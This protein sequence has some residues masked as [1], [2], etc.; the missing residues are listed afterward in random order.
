MFSMAFLLTVAALGLWVFAFGMLATIAEELFFAHKTSSRDSRLLFR[1]DGLPVWKTTNYDR[2]VSQHEYHDLDGQA[3]EMLAKDEHSQITTLIDSRLWR[4]SK[5]GLWKSRVASVGESMQPGSPHW[6][7]WY[8]HNDGQRGVFVGINLGT[9]Q[10]VGYLGKSGLTTAKPPPESCFEVHADSLREQIIKPSMNHAWIIGLANTYHDIYGDIVKFKETSSI[11]ALFIEPGRRR[12]WALDFQLGKSLVMHDGEPVLAAAFVQPVQAGEPLRAVLRMSDAL[13]IVP[14]TNDG[15]GEPT[16]L[17][18]PEPLRRAG[19]L[20]W[21]P[22]SEGHTLVKT[23]EH[24][25]QLTM[26]DAEQRVVGTRDVADRRDENSKPNPL[27]LTA[28]VACFQSPLPVNLFA[29]GQL[30]EVDLSRNIDARRAR[31]LGLEWHPVRGEMESSDIVV[32]LL[33]LQLSAIVWLVLAVRR[34]LRC[35]A[36]RREQWFWGVWTLAF[37]APGYLALRASGSLDVNALARCN[38]QRQRGRTLQD[39]SGSES[40]GALALADAAGYLGR[41]S[42]VLERLFDSLF[43]GLARCGLAPGHAALVAKE[44]RL[45]AGVAV[46][47]SVAF[48]CVVARLMNVAGFGWM[49]TLVDTHVS[50]PMPFL[51]DAFQQPFTVITLLMAVGLAVLQTSR[52]SRGSAWLFVLHRPVSRRAILLSKVTVGLSVLLVCSALPI[53]VYAWW[54]AKPGTH[55]S[56]FEWSMTN[57]TWRQWWSMPPLYLG[58]L[59]T[60]LRPARWFGT[61]L[62]PCIAGFAW[63]VARESFGV[64][65]WPTW[66][67]FVFVGAIDVAL[68]ASLLLIVREREYS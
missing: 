4:Q 62:L 18:I 29:L 51:W 37:G 56:P 5:R 34:L 50:V 14:L 67:E 12:V 36:T 42:R 39:A 63:I 49:K 32:P 7:R 65:L 11:A 52:E 3:V 1:E 59:L 31:E 68:V 40:V 46:L 33:V 2:N 44:L 60:L 8:F 61:R 54:A 28:W 43:A 9:H 58:T 45:A 20:Q 47:A 41:A 57:E 38:P 64:L 24:G 21:V 27:A 10:T 35:A 66:Q 22:T 15:A 23:T 30:P 25:W 26:L 17:P 16:V 6:I 53:V 48:L 55:P 13:H 19:A